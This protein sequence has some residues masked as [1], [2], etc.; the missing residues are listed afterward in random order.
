MSDITIKQAQA[1]MRDAY[2]NGATGVIVSGIVW[3]AAGVFCLAL[4]DKAGVYALL[5]GG[6]A[7]F[8]LSVVLSKA[9]GRRGMHTRGN[10]LGTLASEGTFWLMA[11]IVAAF[12]LYLLRLEWFFPAMLL[13]IGA[14]YLTFQT[15]YGLKLYWA[16]GA[17]LCGFAFAVVF[18]RL[19]PSIAALG[20]GLLEIACAIALFR[21]RGEK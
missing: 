5:A 8:P 2:L 1:D 6:A 12:G 17:M 4:S 13:A 15:I 16:L 19:S 14:R 11:G 10:P 9:L 7:I 20:G 3:V 18:L 21:H